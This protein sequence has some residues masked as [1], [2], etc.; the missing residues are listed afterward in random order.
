MQEAK[1]T[2]PIAFG[3]R[4]RD[5]RGIAKTS[6]NASRIGVSQQTWNG[7]E[8]SRSEPSFA[9]LV[10][11]CHLF[12]VSADYLLGISNERHPSAVSA[13]SAGANSPACAAGGGSTAIIAGGDNAALVEHLTREVAELNEEKS[14]LYNIIEQLS[15]GGAR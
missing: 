8:R 4:L 15:K 3:V 14:R 5:C 6:D 7:W 10:K 1:N 13:N 11:L 12:N 2:S 9:T